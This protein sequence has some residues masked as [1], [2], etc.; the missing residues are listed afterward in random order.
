MSS[1]SPQRGR[2]RRFA[3][4]TTIITALALGA[5]RAGAQ[6]DATRF[7]FE[8]S[9]DAVLMGEDIVRGDRPARLAT[10]SEEGQFEILVRKN[11][12]PVLAPHC[13]STFLVLRM[14]ASIGEDEAT[15][16]AIARKRRVYDGFLEAYRAG[17]PL[18]LDVFA[19]PYGRRLPD[20]QVELTDCNL[21]FVE[22][23]ASGR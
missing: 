22:P 4:A 11:A 16:A 23:A 14:P 17:Q 21:F 6:Q 8:A 20:G 7:R 5:S 12:A 2:I 1:Q 10:V 15:R 18:E 9:R 19:G 13:R 3:L